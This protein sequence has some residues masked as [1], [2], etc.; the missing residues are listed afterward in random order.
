LPPS[1]TRLRFYVH[2]CQQYFFSGE[3]GKPGYFGGLI[4]FPG[5]CHKYKTV[6]YSTQE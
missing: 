2:L 3:V 6:Q 5:T 1:V 4:G